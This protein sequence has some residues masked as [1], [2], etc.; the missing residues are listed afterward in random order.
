M[1]TNRLHLQDIVTETPAFDLAAFIALL[2]ERFYT[3][4][5]N[6][7]RFLVQWLACI[8]SIPE[9]DA[10]AFLPELLDA[11]FLILGDENKEIRNM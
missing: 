5:P 1:H 10:L 7:R 6:T 9:I 8:M 4:K 2:R 3:K 11:I